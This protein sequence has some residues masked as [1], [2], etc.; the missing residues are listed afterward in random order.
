MTDYTPQQAREMMGHALDHGT[1]AR[2]LK[3]L[4]GQAARSKIPAATCEYCD[5]TGDV[6]SADGEWR[7]RC[8][9]EVGK[10]AS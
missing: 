4:A 7:G 6:H 2:A 9:C 5:G 3:S 10:A 8:D 1:T